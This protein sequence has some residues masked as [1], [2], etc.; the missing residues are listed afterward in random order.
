MSEA[1]RDREKKSRSGPSSGSFTVARVQVQELAALSGPAGFEAPA[2]DLLMSDELLVDR[3]LAG[4]PQQYEVLMRRT[5]ARLYRLA[6]GILRDSALA[7]VVIRQAFIHAYESLANFDR[8]LSF[9]DWL[10]RITIHGALGRLKQAKPP[11]RTSMRVRSQELV[12]QL[13]NAVDGLPERLR[14]AFT[15]C[16][17]DQ[18]SLADAGQT[19]GQS[20]DAVRQSAFLGRLRVRR[21]LG[22]RF[23]DA[24]ARAFGLDLGSANDVV[25]AVMARCGIPAR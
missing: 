6:R 7:E 3:L 12:R 24:E 13:E 2:G 19:L 22:M 15:L 10:A 8:R 25:S 5:C 14:V 20:S 4:E 17:L 23:D 9:S 11:D 21:Q 1:K 18:I 16:A